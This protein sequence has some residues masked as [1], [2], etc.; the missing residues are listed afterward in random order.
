MTASAIAQESQ[1]RIIDRFAKNAFRDVDRP[2]GVADVERLVLAKMI[3]DEEVPSSRACLFGCASVRG[4]CGRAC[5][6]G[7]AD[8]AVE[9]GVEKIFGEFIHPLVEE[10]NEFVTG[11]EAR[12]LL[13]AHEDAVSQ[14]ILLTE[15]DGF[16][17]AADCRVDVGVRDVA[18]AQAAVGSCIVGRKDCCG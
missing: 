6:E 4:G 5:D 8:F 13:V 7:Y 17:G 18:L 9:K 10:A 16:C 15:D 1:P 11:V 12:Q 14:A 3:E 2:A